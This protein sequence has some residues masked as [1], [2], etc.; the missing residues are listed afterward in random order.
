M[1]Q[2][3]VL[4]GTTMLDCPVH[5]DPRPVLRWLRDGKPLVRS[6][7]IQ[8]LQNGSLVVRGVTV[9]LY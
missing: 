3:V 8:A 6:L 2:T 1:S 5:G 9:S 7:Q 4:G